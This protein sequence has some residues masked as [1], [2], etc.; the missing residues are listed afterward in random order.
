MDLCQAEI[1]LF[2]V[3]VWF[4]GALAQHSA[5]QGCPEATRPHP[6][7]CDQYYRCALLPSKTAVWITT[8]CRKGLIYRHN[9]SGCIVPDNDWECDL[10]SDLEHNPSEERFYGIDNPHQQAFPPSRTPPASVNLTRTADT[11]Q[12]QHNLPSFAGDNHRGILI[13][14]DQELKNRIRS[15]ESLVEMLDANG[16]KSMERFVEDTDTPHASMDNDTVVKTYLPHSFQE[17]AER[18][19]Y[20]PNNDQPASKPLGQ[21]FL[22]TSHLNSILG[23]YTIHGGE[24]DQSHK[25]KL[26]L[27]PNGKIHPEHLTQIINQQKQLNRIASQMNQRIDPTG[28]VGGFSAF[29]NN[30]VFSRKPNLPYDYPMD[31]NYEMVFPQQYLVDSNGDKKSKAKGPYVSEDIIKSIL[32]I[33]QQMIANHQK[34]IPS[35]E[36]TRPNPEPLPKP[37]LLPLSVATSS[38][39]APPIPMTEDATPTKLKITTTFSSKPIGISFTN[40]YTLGHTTVYDNLRNQPLNGST[41]YNSFQPTFYDIYRNRFVPKDPYIQM[42]PQSFAQHNSYISPTP[43]TALLNRQPIPTYP[44]AVSPYYSPPQGPVTGDASFFYSHLSNSPSILHLQNNVQDSYSVTSNAIDRVEPLD[45]TASNESNDNNSS[46]SDQ[47]IISGET[48]GESSQSDVDELQSNPN[49]THNQKLYE[50]GE[51]ALHYTQYKDSIMPLLGANPGDVRISVATCTLGSREPNR[52]DCF[53]YF[54]C[55]P[56]NGAF[57]SFTCPSFTAF[58]KES[59]LCDTASYHACKS[60]QTPTTTP[61]SIIRYKGSVA[62]PNTYVMKNDI[63]TAQKYVELMRQETNKLLTRNNMPLPAEQIVVLPALGTVSTDDLHTVKSSVKVRRKSS[64]KHSSKITP[65]STFTTSTTTIS[66]TVKRSKSARKGPRCRAEGRIPNPLDQ[67]SYYVCHR[68]SQKKFVKMK[69]TC[70]SGLNYCAASQY[71]SSHC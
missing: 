44:S 41:Y 35:E 20:F 45:L 48:S 14:M 33:S 1:V 12:K 47:T 18:E 30:M 3:A 21:G 38:T 29:A 66:P 7:R 24:G 22:S 36:V 32:Q 31:A 9:R 5:Q 61:S 6:A 55:N 39:A 23:D 46:D 50:I 27:P 28:G 60:Q 43:T 8:Q 26:P 52:T 56:Q 42:M 68:K 2:F 59:R 19:D 58:N 40:P 49:P 25:P 54:V 71:C 69:M 34:T 63:L 64:S 51:S 65:T 10:S 16:H 17:G 4:N 70:T 57:Q 62:N 15:T 11:I 13:L 67:H 37:I 53:K